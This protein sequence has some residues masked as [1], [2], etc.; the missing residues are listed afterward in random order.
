VDRQ[1]VVALA[2]GA[3]ILTSGEALSSPAG[4]EQHNWKHHAVEAWQSP[5]RLVRPNKDSSYIGW[6]R[7]PGTETGCA[8]G[9]GRFG[10]NRAQAGGSARNHA[11]ARGWV[12]FGPQYTFIPGRGIADEGCNL[13]TSACPNHQRDGQ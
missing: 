8:E 4:T 2:L 9:Y 3:M 12:Y 11:P 13:P 1:S 6:S 5:G 10:C 7:V